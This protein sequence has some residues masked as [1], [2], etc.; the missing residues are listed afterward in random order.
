M[1][2]SVDSNEFVW[3]HCFRRFWGASQGNQVGLSFV[4]M[5]WRHIPI[6]I[7]PVVP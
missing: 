7:D 1:A 2:F 6:E 4:E 5:Y 3:Q